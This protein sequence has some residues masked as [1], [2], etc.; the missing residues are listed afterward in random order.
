MK[1]KLLIFG[2]S[3]PRSGG[4]LVSNMLSSHRDIIITKDLIHFF[5]H[6]FNKYKPIEKDKNK[7][8]LVEELCLRILIRNRIKL[9]PKIIIKKIQYSKNYDEIIREISNYL[10]SKLKK[11]K[12]SWGNSKYRMEKYRNF[13]KIK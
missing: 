2:T 7:Y 3:T 4:S 9:S 1:N 12:N 6:I 8:L 10:L 13:F 11:K 5:R